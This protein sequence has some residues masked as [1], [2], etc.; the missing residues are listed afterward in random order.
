MEAR[1]SAVVTLEDNEVELADS[2]ATAPRTA[3]APTMQRTQ[4]GGRGV[5]A[6]VMVTIGPGENEGEDVDGSSS[7]SFDRSNERLAG[8]R[9][10]GDGAKNEWSS[11]SSS[12]E[13]SAMSY[14]EQ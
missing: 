6:R 14:E 1:P 12:T 3:M 4:L 9:R 10:G 5:I 8:F 13:S 2:V 11:S 7:S